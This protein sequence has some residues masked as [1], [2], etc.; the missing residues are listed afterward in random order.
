V[1][2]NGYGP[3][4][5][6]TFSSCYAMTAATR[7][8]GS[9][10]IG[11]SLA[12][13]SSD[14]L[15]PELLPLPAGIAGEL[16]VGGDGLARGYLDRPDL[17]AERFVPDPLGRE[18]GARLYRT[19]DRARWGSDGNLEFLGRLD[20]QLKIRGFRVEPG[21]VE[22]VLAE[23]PSVAS[24]VV[25]ARPSRAGGVVLA[26]Y[27]VP[28][29]GPVSDAELRA[30]LRD[31]LPAFMQPSSLTVLREWPLT[32]TG[33]VDRRHLPAPEAREERAAPK[34]APR[35]P[36]EASLV[37]MWE[38]LLGV[39]P[40]GIHDSFFDLGGHSLVATQVISRVRQE[41]G[42]APPLRLL[43]EEPTIARL[44]AAITEAKAARRAVPEIPILRRQRRSSDAQPRATEKVPSES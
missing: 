39:E 6:S 3:T 17:T 12:N 40:V 22:V 42:T 38:E 33:K 19:G 15:D 41:H 36:I 8:P 1:L 9:V 24:A 26:A 16:F 13:S 44:A 34:V 11:R 21:E 28:A 31:R 30:W 37:R 43:F 35:D 5:N 23:H 2:V 7:F 10:P 29:S 20:T 14:V 32:P 4:E 25:Q 18:P 27:V